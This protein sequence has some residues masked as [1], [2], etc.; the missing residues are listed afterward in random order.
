MSKIILF[1][2]DMEN[3]WVKKVSGAPLEN[4]AI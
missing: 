1:I 3:L 2:Y 4:P